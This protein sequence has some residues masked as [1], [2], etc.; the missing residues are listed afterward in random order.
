MLN[1]AYRH[2]AIY[3]FP[4]IFIIWCKTEMYGVI[5]VPH[6][7]ASRWIDWVQKKTLSERRKQIW[8]AQMQHQKNVPT[9]HVCKKA[10]LPQ[11]PASWLHLSLAKQDV[12][13][14]LCC[15][16]RFAERRFL[17]QSTWT[18]AVCMCSSEAPTKPIQRQW[19]SFI[20]RTFTRTVHRPVFINL[21]MGVEYNQ[22][23]WLVSPHIHKF[24]I[25]LDPSCSVARQESSVKAV[26]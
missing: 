20:K 19:S 21:D 9:P 22:I 11:T 24:E 6:S 23:S 13:N 14:S 17:I 1:N 12:W 5:F 18:Y 2:F 10:A 26:I 15:G 3:G 8:L 7:R 25:S 4:S 16:R